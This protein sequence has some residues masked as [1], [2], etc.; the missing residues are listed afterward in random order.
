ME[1][2]I[3]NMLAD[4]RLE[5]LDEAINADE[6]CKSVRMEVLELQKKLETM[7]LTDEQNEIVQKLLSKTNAS[8]ALYGQ[9][10]YKYGFRDGVKLMC[11][12]K[13]DI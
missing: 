8:G 1:E 11:E 5:I 3:L 7:D 10:A 13:D 12:I 9:I 4:Q 2:G 6:E